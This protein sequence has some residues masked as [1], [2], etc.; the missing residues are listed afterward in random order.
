MGR[1]PNGASSIYLGAD[2]N[3]HGRVTVGIKDDGK[4]DRRHVQAKTEAAVIRRVRALEKERDSG[5][6]R[7]AGQRWTVE[8]WLTHWIEN[9]AVPPAISGYTHDGY[10]VDIVHYLVPGIG[11]HKLD[12]LTP[13]HLERLYAKMLD[14]SRAAGTAHHVHRTIRAALNEAMRRG[15]LTT[16]PATLA[17]APTPDEHEVEPYEVD[18]IR[19]ILKVAGE[20][21]NSARWAIALALGLRQG[22]ALGLRWTDVDLTGAVLRVRRSRLRP[23]YG[24]GCGETCGKKPGY[25]PQRVQVNRDTKDTKSR[26]GKRAIGLPGE[27][28]ALLREH[29]ER[30]D[31]DRV[32]AG[33]LWCDEGW[34]FAM[35]DGRALS[36]N[37]DYREWKA[38][39]KAA[40]VNDGRLHDARHTSATVLL[41]LGGP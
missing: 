13:E 17:K 29:K 30:Q 6:V 23:K 20:R 27:I 12:K 32:A 5:R 41:L 40:G 21:R 33:D 14:Q 1:R 4:P 2:G 25:C 39:L 35:P 11:A 31:V 34:V 18:E 36:P 3:W 24:H 8:K 19:R 37:T 9:I 26:A 16:N 28:V 22:E 10:K 15:H 38:L 7:K